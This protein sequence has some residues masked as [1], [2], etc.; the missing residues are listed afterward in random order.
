[1]GAIAIPSRTDIPP[2]TMDSV[3][4]GRPK[5][6]CWDSGG[7]KG[8]PSHGT[9]SKPQ[10]GHRGRV[11]FIYISFQIVWRQDCVPNARVSN[12][13]I[14]GSSNY[15]KYLPGLVAIIYVKSCD[16]TIDAMLIRIHIPSLEE[17]FFSLNVRWRGKNARDN[18]F[19]FRIPVSGSF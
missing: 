10:R 3:L 13:P 14:F 16:P 6:G 5:Y 9:H 8:D 1:M 4:I 19:S 15:K 17:T 18:Y 12:H 11:Q 2:S 7:G